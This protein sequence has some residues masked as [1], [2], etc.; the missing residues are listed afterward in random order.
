M[1]LTTT[2]IRQMTQIVDNSYMT[3]VLWG[4]REKLKIQIVN[5]S[6]KM[7]EAVSNLT[8]EKCREIYEQIIEKYK[9]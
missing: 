1:I 2:P 5:I 3:L 6:D 8:D 4:I 7:V 9:N